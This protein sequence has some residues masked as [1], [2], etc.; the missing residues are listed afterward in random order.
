MARTQKP[1]YRPGID[2]PP[3]LVRL[4]HWMLW[5]LAASVGLIGLLTGR[6]RSG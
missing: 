4:R 5:A 3:R 1:K 2:D 6:K